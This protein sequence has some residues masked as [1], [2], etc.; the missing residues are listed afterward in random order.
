MAWMCKRK[1]NVIT[2]Y[3]GEQDLSAFYGPEAYLREASLDMVHLKEEPSLSM[4][5]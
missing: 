4:K 3:Q 2:E 5:Q 1:Q